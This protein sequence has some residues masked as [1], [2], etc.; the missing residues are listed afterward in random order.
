MGRLS[1]RRGAER[2]ITLR[3]G[4]GVFTVQRSPISATGLENP[5]G[6]LVGVIVCI[7]LHQCGVELCRWSVE[8][9]EGE[10]EEEKRLQKWVKR[11]RAR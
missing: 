1:Y 11:K 10:E 8:E 9:K 4:G 6:A 7:A 3:N 5:N 2:R